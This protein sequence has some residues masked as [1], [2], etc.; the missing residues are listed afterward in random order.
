MRGYVLAALAA[1]A[2]VAGCAKAPQNEPQG[3][4]I[5]V[6]TVESDGN[7]K[8]GA[9]GRFPGVA[10]CKATLEQKKADAGPPPAGV[11]VKYAC[12]PESV[13]APVF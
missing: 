1:T 7:L 9:L 5:G 6:Y 8:A 11:A 2:L 4:I 10:D 12:L 3:E 13:F